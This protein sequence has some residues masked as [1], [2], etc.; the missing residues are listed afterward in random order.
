MYEINAL[1]FYKAQFMVELLVANF[2]FAW[3]MKRR[4]H[5]IIRLIMS[6]IVAIILAFAIP[7]INY[8][9]LYISFLFILLS[10]VSICALAFCFKESFINIV[11]SGLSGYSVQH[12]AYSLYQTFMVAT[13]FDGGNS[14][15]IYG[16]GATVNF[17]V[18]TFAIYIDFYI[19]TYFGL[20]S[21]FKK[22]LKKDE[23]F[24]V[25]NMWLFFLVIFMFISAIVL[26]SIMI[27]KYDA[28]N[29]QISLI[30]TFIYSII[31]CLLVLI[32][33]FKLKEV[34]TTKK[35]LEIV[36]HLWKEDREH[37][38]LAKEN[39]KLI[40]IKCHDL[41]HQIHNLAENKVNP[42]AL[43]EIEKS[44]M[45]Y[46][47]IVKTGNDALDVLLSEKSLFCNENKISLTQIVNGQALSFMQDYDI[48]SLFG[49]ALDNAIEY[50]LNVEEDK[51]FIRLNVNNFGDNLVIHIEN[52]FEGELTYDNG[53]PKTTKQ[54][55]DYHGFGLVSIRTIVENYH[56]DLFVKNSGNLFTI[57]ILIPCNKGENGRI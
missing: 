57:N 31:S 9:A 5:F 26:N 40:N 22:N 35:E 17:E 32:V 24:Y 47:S 34:K 53:L 52:Y 41:K 44:V 19:F 51:R 36:Q 8:D 27:Y 13:L 10:I 4:D 29:N 12:I 2:L 50:L 37:Y 28:K 20:Y 21:M 45:I 39:I 43:Q 23:D 11:F 54:N 7:I 48:Y 25:T 14:L 49:N 15:N 42:N 55:T 33:Q 46:D 6:S 1:F 56:G 16:S 3:K 38:D 30:V 18:F